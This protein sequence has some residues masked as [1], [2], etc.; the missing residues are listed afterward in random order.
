MRD[1]VSEKV[2]SLYLIRCGDETLYCGISDDVPAR[3]KAHQAGRGA[4]YT[5]GRGPLALVYQEV[6]GTHSQ[7]LRREC[8][9][10]KLSRKQ[11]QALLTG[12]PEKEGSAAMT[13]EQVL[14]NARGHMGPC[15][16]CPVCNGLACGNSI[17]GPGS[18]GSGT[19]FH[20][21]YSAWQEILLNMDTIAENTPVDTGTELFG[22]QFSMPVFAAPIG[23]VQNHYGDLLT[24]EAYTQGLVKGCVDA[25]ICA[26]TGDGVKPFVFEAGCQAMKDCGMAVP[27]VKPWNQQLVYEKIDQAKAAGARVLCMDIDASGLPFLKNTTPPSGSKTVRELREMIDYAGVPFILK[28]IMTPAG[29]EKAME[30]GASGIVVSNHGGRVLDHTPATAWVLEKISQTVGGRM[31]V[32]VDGGIRTGADIFRA[33]ALGAD[34]VLIGRPFVTAVYGGGAE[35]VRAYVDNL[36]AQLR[37]VMQMC[38][39]HSLGEITKDC[40]WKP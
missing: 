16:V 21:N 26:F 35:G 39:C 10:K 20:R 27:T 2:W 3:F 29:A 6:C 14:H 33:L 40:I 32:L 24:E 22:R 37:D 28:G 11:K 17:P 38:G 18:K 7:A 36:S 34:G 5:R 4:K 8:Q 13:Y 9:V 15:K 31:T 19:V 25:G 23:A 30:A 12:G 1:A